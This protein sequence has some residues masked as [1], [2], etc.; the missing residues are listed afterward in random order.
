MMLFPVPPIFSLRVRQLGPPG[1]V[2]D[3][4]HQPPQH[5]TTPL[6]FDNPPAHSGNDQTPSRHF[7][8]SL[9]RRRSSTSRPDSNPSGMKANGAFPAQR[10]RWWYLDSETN[11]SSRQPL[12]PLILMG[13]LDGIASNPVIGHDTDILDE[14]E[15]E[16]EDPELSSAL[17]YH[18]FLFGQVDMAEDDPSE[19]NTPT[20]PPPFWTRLDPVYETDTRYPVTEPP[21]I[22]PKSEARYSGSSTSTGSSKN[23]ISP[24]IVAESSG[25]SPVTGLA[26]P[27]PS[28][29]PSSP[30][31]LP[32]STA[33]PLSSGHL[34]VPGSSSSV[35]HLPGSQ[36]GSLSQ[37][38][39]ARS[40]FIHSP[41]QPP[42][43][44]AV[45]PRH[46]HDSSAH[47]GGSQKKALVALGIESAD[48]AKNRS[49]NGMFCCCSFVIICS[50]RL[51]YTCR[52]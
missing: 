46:L 9:S 49:M 51:D 48:T 36:S 24:S 5:R 20:A 7:F 32:A 50:F 13:R 10:E 14:L 47:F 45:C 11:L 26:I 23:S 16:V 35:I 27:G 39:S 29:G 1:T 44:L 41:V 31:R 28:P 4:Y 6:R 22:P 25:N 15:E 2:T 40:S 21:M 33:S 30:A 8:P 18:Q 42:R 19:P 17:L 12:D 3:H 52:S 38:S 34:T 37:S 43:P